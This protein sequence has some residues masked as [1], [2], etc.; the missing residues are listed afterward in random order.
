MLEQ[1][2]VRERFESQGNTI[3]IESPAAFRQTVHNDR[4]KWAKVAKDANISID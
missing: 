3:R 4:L 1:P 2:D